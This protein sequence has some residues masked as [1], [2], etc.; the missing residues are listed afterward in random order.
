MQVLRNTALLAAR[1]LLA[2][3]FL[4]EGWLKVTHYSAI[5][6]YMEGYG[7]SGRLLPLVILT[8]LGCGG[9]VALGLLTRPAAVALAGFCLLTALFFHRDYGDPDQAIQLGKNLA[10][11]GGFL[12]LFAAGPGDWSLDGW[13]KSLRNPGRRH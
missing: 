5:L 13:W 6:Q 8:E 3:I 10:M 9:L 4:V 1:L 7:V 11:T 12:A 2:A